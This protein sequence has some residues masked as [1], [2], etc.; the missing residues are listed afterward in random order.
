[1]RCGIFHMK[2]VWTKIPLLWEKTKLFQI[3]IVI[4]SGLYWLSNKYLNIL[5]A[6]WRSVP[7]INKLILQSGCSFF[8]SQIQWIG[9]NQFL[10]FEYK[11]VFANLIR[12][13][14]EFFSFHFQFTTNI[15]TVIIL[16]VIMFSKNLSNFNHFQLRLIYI[17]IF[18]GERASRGSKV[19][20]H[21][22]KEG[23][24]LGLNHFISMVYSKLHIAPTHQHP[25]NIFRL[26][27][28]ELGSVWLYAMHGMWWLSTEWIRTLAPRCFLYTA[29]T[30]TT[31][32]NWTVKRKA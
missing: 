9:H 5:C 21:C 11:I 29:S 23:V 6:E 20:F 30:L 31:Q 22:P 27:R 16:D 17:I 19:Y 13:I 26:C 28:V 3:C 1:M 10:T 24:H 14:I 2:F 32:P 4:Y 25:Y 15:I 18:L 7:Q 12:R 8:Q